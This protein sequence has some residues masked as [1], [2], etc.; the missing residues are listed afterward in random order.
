[1]GGGGYGLALLFMLLFLSTSLDWARLKAFWL[2]MALG[3]SAITAA[4]HEA[5]KLDV[6]PPEL[7]GFLQGL[8][9]TL[10]AFGGVVGVPLAARLYERY[11][12]WGSVFGMLACI[13]AIG[14]ITAVL[15]ARADRIPLAQL[16]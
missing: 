15:F 5:N 9:N 16:L 13:Y 11:H 2:T 4:G 7:T 10:A 3:S 6:A 1:M 12:T 14:A 8:S